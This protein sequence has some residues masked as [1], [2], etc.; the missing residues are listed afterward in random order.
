MAYSL[1]QD[2]RRDIL[3]IRLD[4]AHPDSATLRKFAFKEKGEL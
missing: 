2:A 1:R 4:Q 3:T